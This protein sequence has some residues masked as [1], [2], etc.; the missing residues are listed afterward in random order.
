MHDW[1]SPPRY[2]NASISIS[3]QTL[4]FSFFF[5][6]PL[7]SINISCR[8]LLCFCHSPAWNQ[9]SEKGRKSESKTIR[10]L[11]NAS[12]VRAS[13][14]FKSG[15]FLSIDE[16]CCGSFAH[17]FINLHLYVEKRQQLSHFPASSTEQSCSFHSRGREWTWFCSLSVINRRISQP[18]HATTNEQKPSG[19]PER[20]SKAHFQLYRQMTHFLIGPPIIVVGIGCMQLNLSYIFVGRMEKGVDGAE[21]MIWKN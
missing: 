6:P 11:K 13:Q 7:P 19:R 3:S 9:Q 17:L 16:R 8:A 15:D 1:V 10:I 2:L 20:P 12:S 21:G 18:S 5:F 14:P 4:I